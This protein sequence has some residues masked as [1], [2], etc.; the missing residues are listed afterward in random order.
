MQ[1]PTTH[2]IKK[3]QQVKTTMCL[4][5]FFNIFSCRASAV[6]HGAPLPWLA[7]ERNNQ[8]TPKAQE[9]KKRSK[10]HPRQTN[11][12]PPSTDEAEYFDYT[13]REKS[14]NR[15]TR[16]DGLLPVHAPLFH[17]LSPQNSST[18]Y[19]NKQLGEEVGQSYPE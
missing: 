8:N 9:E 18:K 7:G 1:P 14:E 6:C 4:D 2:F 5:Y 10:K 13:P 15:K 19:H 12:T 16:Q 17:S 11:P 3:T